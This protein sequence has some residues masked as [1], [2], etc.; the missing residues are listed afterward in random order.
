MRVVGEAQ[1]QWAPLRRKYNLFLHN[2]SILNKPEDPNTPRL[3]SGDLPVSDSKQL[4][5]SEPSPDANNGQYNQ[6]AYVDEPLLSWDFS[7]LSVDSQLVGS[8]N[9]NWGGFGREIFTDTGVYALRMDAAG[10]QEEPG[11]LIS[12]SSQVN[13][14]AYATQTGGMTLDQ[15]AVMLATAVSIDFDYFSRK[16]SGAM[17]FM[18][19]WLP[20]GGDGVGGAAA[21]EAAGEAAAGETATG[22]EGEI[23]SGAVSG[24]GETSEGEEV[25]GNQSDSWSEQ[26]G[27]DGSGRGSGGGG[28]GGDGGDGGGWGDFL[29]DIL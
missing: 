23:G 24:V 20:I 25:W 7:L 11:H 1:Q 27:G 19:M 29:N 13:Q 12:K 18:P 28:G 15:R 2:K 10:L 5:A 21:G 22:A 9:R 14:S 26:T 16:R 17:G 4:Q 3:A 8:V 6:F